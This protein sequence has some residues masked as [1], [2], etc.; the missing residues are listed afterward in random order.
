[1]H[2][3]VSTLSSIACNTF[4]RQCTSVQRSLDDIS[5]CK[6]PSGPLLSLCLLHLTCASCRHVH[7]SMP[8]HKQCRRAAR[9][10][11]LHPHRP[12][13]CASCASWRCWCV[14]HSIAAYAPLTVCMHATQAAVHVVAA[15]LF[16]SGFLLT[17]TELSGVSTCSHGAAHSDTRGEPPA[18]SSWCLAPQFSRV[19]VLLLDGLRWDVAA[20][21]ARSASPGRTLGLPALHA[22]SAQLGR[23]SVLT[24]FVAD[25]PTTTQQRLKGLLT[26]ACPTPPD[27]ALRPYTT[28]I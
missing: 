25:P 16:A 14:L 4:T 22:L 24:R 9:G 19:V 12:A 15:A 26:G 1:M 20:G 23:P 2:W 11:I 13:P 27:S 28:A 7:D 17:R 5:C 10:A 18:H 8:R 6:H 21:T 3:T